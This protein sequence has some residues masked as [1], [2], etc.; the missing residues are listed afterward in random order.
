MDDHLLQRTSPRTCSSIELHVRCKLP[1]PFYHPG[2]FSLV[3]LSFDYFSPDSLSSGQ[4]EIGRLEIGD[5]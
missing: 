2:S 1:L 3:F 4:L 5:E